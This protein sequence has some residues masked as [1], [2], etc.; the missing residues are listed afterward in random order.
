MGISENN[1]T[2]DKNAFEMSEV[3]IVNTA[4]HPHRASC[5]TSFMN[6]SPI[7]LRAYVPYAVTLQASEII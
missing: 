1:H 7:P 6:G 3:T 4:G 5:P 2:I